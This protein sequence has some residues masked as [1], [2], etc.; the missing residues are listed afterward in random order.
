M[1]RSYLVDP[2]KTET[3]STTNII[4]GNAFHPVDTVPFVIWTEFRLLL[5]SIREISESII[6]KTNKY[7]KLIYCPKTRPRYDPG[8]VDVEWPVSETAGSR[9]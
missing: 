8:P 1:V 4:G 9:L 7:G 6:G 5:S 3:G 2:M